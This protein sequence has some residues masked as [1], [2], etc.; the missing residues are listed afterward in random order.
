MGYKVK[1]NYGL[2]STKG[3]VTKMLNKILAKWIVQCV[4]NIYLHQ[5]EVIPGIWFNI[6]QLILLLI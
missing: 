2:I 4:K 6:R 5:E 3:I 1:E